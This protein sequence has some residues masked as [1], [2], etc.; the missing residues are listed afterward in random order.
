MFL[1]ELGFSLVPPFCGFWELFRK[2][3]YGIFITL[4]A[5]KRGALGGKIVLITV[6]MRSVRRHEIQIIY[7]GYLKIIERYP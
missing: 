4:S 6:L 2:V 5:G 1:G 7:R 3:A